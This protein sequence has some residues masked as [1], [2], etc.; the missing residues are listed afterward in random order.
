MIKGK[1]IKSVSVETSGDYGFVNLGGSYYFYDKL[2]GKSPRYYQH[3][4]S[5]AKSSIDIWDP[6]FSK[7]SAQ[8]F[9]SV[10]NNGVTINIITKYKKKDFWDQ[11]YEILV[12]EFAD[13]IKSVLKG[14]EVTHQLYIHCYFAPQFKHDW[15]DRYLIIDKK[16]A[17]LIGSSLDDQIKPQRNFGIHHIVDPKD[18]SLITSKMN[19]CIEDRILAGNTKNC[20]SRQSITK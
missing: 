19:K 17:Y 10:I 7:R 3:I 15:H 11:G 1:D 4:L 18:V 12:N 13:E 2:S 16:E 20:Y 6:Y 5:E 8:V 9:D 14:N